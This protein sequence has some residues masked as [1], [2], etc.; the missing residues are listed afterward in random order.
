[1]RPSFRV[2]FRPPTI[3]LNHSSKRLMLRIIFLVL[4]IAVTTSE[5]ERRDRKAKVGSG[6][7]LT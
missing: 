2:W 4:G 1:M 5:F 7:V 3:D 6:S